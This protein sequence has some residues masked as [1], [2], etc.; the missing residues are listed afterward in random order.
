MKN[1]NKSA[2]TINRMLEQKVKGSEKQIAKMYAKM[3]NEIRQELAKLYEKYEVGGKLTYVEMAKYDRLTKFLN[4]VNKLVT[5]QYKG[6]KKVIYDVLGESYLDG[7]YLTAWAVETDT[8]SRLAYSAVTPETI[9]A[10]I[11]NPL[12]NLSERLHKNMVNTVFEIRQEV[13]Q[14]LVQGDT[15]GKMAG[16][17]KDKLEVKTSDAMRIVRTESH[18]V[19]QASQLD[20]AIHA[21][22]NGVVMMKEWASM[23]DERV[24]KPKGKNKA[25]HRM[26]DSKKIPVGENFKGK[27]GEGPAPGQLGTAPSE[28][29]NC[30]CILLYSVEKVE[31]VDV[32]ELDG[33]AFETWKE[34]RLKSSK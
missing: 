12:T 30:R 15:Y 23:E 28:N 29:I 19:S 24:R 22:N 32:K 26:L 16:R 3:L 6:L 25:N 20:S 13:T 10:A 4:Y 27:L 33:M 34:E 11:D 14:G 17:L 1:L 18:R 31:K 8:L 2:E 21:N 5:V 9:A 7:Y